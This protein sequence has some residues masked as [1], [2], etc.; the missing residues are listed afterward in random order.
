MKLEALASK[1]QLI[2]ITIDDEAIVTKYGEEI[3]FYI[4]DRQDMDTFMKLASI[5]GDSQFA[6][7]AKVVQSLVLNE[8]GKPVL[9]DGNTLPIDIMVKV[10]ETVVQ[11]LGNS[12]TQTS[13]S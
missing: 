5:E 12:M 4:Y 8:K 9:D 11:R 1:P 2:N 10:V 6:E 13:V 3:E 7:I